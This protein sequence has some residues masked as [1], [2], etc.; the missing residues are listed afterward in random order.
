MRRAVREEEEINVSGEVA[1]WRENLA[2]ERQ[3]PRDL[4]AVRRRAERAELEVMALGQ[5]TRTAIHEGVLTSL[6]CDQAE[7]LAPSGAELYRL[8]AWTGAVET[9]EVI[10]SVRARW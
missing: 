3:H 2:A 5:V 1:R 9:A 6:V 8:A 4:A 7:K 10:R